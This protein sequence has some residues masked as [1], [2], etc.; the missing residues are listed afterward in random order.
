MFWSD[1]VAQEIIN[2]GQYKPYW[3]DDMKTPS[4]YPAISGL[5]GPLLHDLVYKSLRHLGVDAKTTF[6]INDF[7]PIDGLS[8]DLE[9]KF[10][11]YMGFP[12]KTA[13]SPG[14]GAEN[15]ADF[16]AND[17][18]EVLKKLGVEAEFISSW[19]LYQQGK[20]D[21]V[22]REALDNREEILNVYAEVSGSQKR[23]VGWYPLQVICE[24]C[25]KLGT[26]KVVGWDGELVT[27]KCEEDMV[28][29][30][31]GC[32]NEG[33]IS[34]FGGNGKLP[35]KVDWPAHWKVLGIT[36]EGAGKDHSSKGGSRDVARELC[37]RVFNYP[38]PFHL[39]YEFILIGG[40][41]MSTSKGRGIKA[42][43]ATNLMPA[44]LI[45]FLYSRTDYRQQINFDPMQ[46]M[47][48]PDLFDDYDR[49]FQAYLED[50]EEPSLRAFEVSQI[51]DLPKKEKTFIPRFRDVVNY[52]QQPG[53]IFA[54]YAELKGSELTDFEKE[55]L[56]ERI[57]Y[58]KIWVEQYAPDEFKMGFAAELSE[59]AKSI[60]DEQKKYLEAL[61][62]L[63]ENATDADQLQTDVY[64]LSKDLNI[65]AK[66]AF[67]AIYLVTIG[68][69][70][71][72]RAGAFLMEQE[73]QDL[74][75]RFKE[76]IS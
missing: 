73:K 19:D 35:W 46:T 1:K 5:K 17:Y 63:I 69:E 28:K 39:P 42:R 67:A 40:K 10:T 29:W 30:A 66:K 65:N 54:K 56:E 62:P 38:E 70:H 22:I 16:F 36:I 34:P 50:G 6:I 52:M 18:I 31:I 27:Y 15:F 24:K 49:C 2:S 43:E 59:D 74:I 76:A 21:E 58:A 4:G 14:E 72:P 51:N 26:T 44:E 57:K 48:I 3:V 55:I 41:K 37:K 75:K 9:E 25:G 11:Q 13:P 12:L 33:K 68:K 45:R 32:G 8:S 53:D 23:E 7:D 61:I 47:A 60:D 71:G 20:F 64:Q